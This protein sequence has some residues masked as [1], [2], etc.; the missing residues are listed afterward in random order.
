MVNINN[1]TIY[2]QEGNH[3]TI[4]PFFTV[5]QCVEKIMKRTR[6][7]I[8]IYVFDNQVKDVAKLNLCFPKN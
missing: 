6:L 3:K 1:F 2:L 8:V 4:F 5:P 7:H